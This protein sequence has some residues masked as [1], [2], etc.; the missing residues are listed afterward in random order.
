MMSATT[1][2]ENAFRWLAERPEPFQAL[3]RPVVLR[4]MQDPGVVTIIDS[5]SLVN[6]I[7]YAWSVVREMRSGAAFS[8]R[9]ARDAAAFESM[10]TGT[11]LSQA[12][13]AYYYVDEA[14]EGEREQ[15]RIALAA[16]FFQLRHASKPTNLLLLVKLLQWALRDQTFLEHVLAQRPIEDFLP[17][18]DAADLRTRSPLR[19]GGEPRDRGI[20]V[21]ER[22]GAAHSVGAPRSQGVVYLPAPTYTFFSGKRIQLLV[23][24]EDHGRVLVVEGYCTE[25]APTHVVV[26]ATASDLTPEE[27]RMGGRIVLYG[28]NSVIRIG[29]LPPERG[30]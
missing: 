13:D 14:D 12:E 7:E 16:A 26:V 4:A 15:L 27:R 8:P 30:A 19:F 11:A 22:S 29:L 18:D 21:D 25:I 20:H 17:P 10:A 24:I 5:Y 1:E 28:M 9:L 3:F 6:H 2:F 23:R